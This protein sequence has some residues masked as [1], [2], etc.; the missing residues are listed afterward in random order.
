MSRTPVTGPGRALLAMLGAALGACTHV[1]R[2]P[3]EPIT[4]F[5]QDA[6]IP[7]DVEFVVPAGMRE[8][9]W[10]RDYGGDTYRIEMGPFLADSCAAMTRA[11]F[12]DVQ[13]VDEQSGR[14]GSR[15]VVTARR[16]QVVP[17]F[18]AG[19]LAV[20][21]EWAVID[22]QGQDVW[23]ETV[24]GLHKSGGSWEK[25]IRGATQDLL[26]RTLAGLRAS[27]EIRRLHA[28]S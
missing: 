6:P 15:V 24:W 10:Q 26:D 19:F 27:P 14:H 21:V 18:F 22:A 11:A 9:A 2:A 8:A 3:E 28:G 25:V 12:R 13:I 4:T 20:L 1:W 5:Q 7:L 16:V 23:R 17:A